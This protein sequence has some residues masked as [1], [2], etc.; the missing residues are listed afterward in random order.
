[1]LTSDTRLLGWIA[2][3]RANWIYSNIFPREVWC[4]FHRRDNRTNNFNES[5]HNVFRDIFPTHG[6]LWTFVG[7]LIIHH[8]AELTTQHLHSYGSSPSSRSRQQIDKETALYNIKQLY[9]SNQLIDYEY[10]ERVASFI[11]DM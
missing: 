8:S 6:P 11:K 9:L 1:M 4:V 10:V 2:Y 7:R 3:V 5:K